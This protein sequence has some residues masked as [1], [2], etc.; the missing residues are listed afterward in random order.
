M[1]KIQIISSPL[2]DAW[3]YPGRKL[4][5]HQ[6]KGFCYGPDLRDTL[7]KV[8]ENME[9]YHLTKYLTDNRAS[10]AVVNEDSEWSTQHFFPRA[11]AAGWKHWAIVLPVNVI[12]SIHLKRQAQVMSTHGFMNVKTFEDP[13]EA[14]KWIDEL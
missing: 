10:G 12:G 8:V 4:A 5:H 11:V 9:R 6:M 14:M 1:E 3:V 2:I 7:L 13:R